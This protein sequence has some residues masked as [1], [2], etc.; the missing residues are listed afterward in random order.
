[1]N[2]E[3]L[4]QALQKAQQELT[5]YQNNQAPDLAQLTELR[6]AVWGAQQALAQAQGKIPQDELIASMTAD[7]AEKVMA[8][9]AQQEAQ[10]Q[11]EQEQAL[12]NQARLAFIAAG[13][14]E[15]DFAQE[16]PMLRA[17][18]VRQRTLAAMTQPAQ[19]SAVDK[20]ITARNS[21]KPL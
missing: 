15:A 1:M 19:L 17:E 2:I 12:Y 18:L 9:R 16:W 3:A 4:V 5:D 8:R 14:V 11:T 21:T 20:W 6:R 7:V 10:A 13:G